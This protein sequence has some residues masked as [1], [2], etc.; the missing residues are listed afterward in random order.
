[1]TVTLSWPGKLQSAA[2]ATPPFDARLVP[3]PEASWLPD[4]SPH[5]MIEGDNLPTLQC[6]QSTHRGQV[7]CI[8]IDPPYNTGQVRNYQDDFRG[9]RTIGQDAPIN[10]PAG[11]T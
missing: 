3:M 2:L 6:L 4:Q 1:M 9:I 11:S 8:Y 7:K 5:M 10:T